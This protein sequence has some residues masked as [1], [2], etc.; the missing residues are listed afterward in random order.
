MISPANTFLTISEAYNRFC[1]NSLSCR[2]NKFNIS[3]VFTNTIYCGYPEFS[4]PGCCGDSCNAFVIVSCLRL[5][6]LLLASLGLISFYTLC[7]VVDHLQLICSF[8]CEKGL[9]F[10]HFL[11]VCCFFSFSIFTATPTT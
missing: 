6:S 7:T 1:L 3:P 9:N 8:L 2:N 11:I 4:S 10:S 5:S